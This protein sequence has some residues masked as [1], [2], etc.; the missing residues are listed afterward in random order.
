MFWCGHKCFVRFI[1]SI[2]VAKHMKTVFCFCSA[3]LRRCP[4]CCS[5]HTN[6]RK[7]V[8]SIISC[9]ELL[10]IRRRA[11]LGQ[12]QKSHG[13]NTKLGQQQISHGRSTLLEQSYVN[14]TVQGLS[15]FVG[16]KLPNIGHGR[17]LSWNP[18]L[19]EFGIGNKFVYWALGRMA[20]NL[21]WNPRLD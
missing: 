3:M 4:T 8:G 13:R 21:S 19:D 10:N 1:C 20:E 6:S 12:Q 5:V 2:A 16:Q 14:L 11:K 15:D 17:N 9:Q 7:R 18:K